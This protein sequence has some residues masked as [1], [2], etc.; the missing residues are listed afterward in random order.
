MNHTPH[1]HNYGQQ[2]Y[3]AYQ[4]PPMRPMLAYARP[5]ANQPV[6][7][8]PGQIDRIASQLGTDDL[9]NLQAA[10]EKLNRTSTDS[11]A[12]QRDS[13]ESTSDSG[14]PVS[15]ENRSGNK[16]MDKLIEEMKKLTKELDVKKKT[17]K[18]VEKKIKELNEELKQYE[19]KIRLRDNLM[20]IKTNLE[21]QDEEIQTKINRVVSEM[22][23]C[24]KRQS[25]PSNAHNA[26]NAQDVI[27]RPQPT[28]SP[29]PESDSVTEPQK[30]S[31]LKPA[32]KRSNPNPSNT[33][34][35]P[36]KVRIQDDNDSSTPKTTLI[37]PPIRKTPIPIQHKSTPMPGQHKSTPMPTQHKSTPTTSFDSPS[38][39]GSPKVDRLCRPHIPRPPVTSGVRTSRP[40]KLMSSRNK[41]IG[42]DSN[43]NSV[44]ATA[45][46][47]NAQ[48]VHEEAPTPSQEVNNAVLD[49]LEKSLDSISDSIAVQI[50]KSIE[51][52]IATSERVSKTTIDNQTAD[53]SGDKQVEIPIEK[54]TDKAI[55]NDIEIVDIDSGDEDPTYDIVKVKT[56]KPDNKELVS[57]VEASEVSK[58]SETPSDA[59]STT[60]TSK[61]SPQKASD[62]TVSKKVYQFSAFDN[63]EFEPSGIYSLM[64][65]KVTAGP[66][67]NQKNPKN[68]VIT[69]K[70][71]K[72]YLIASF[73][74]C[75]VRRYNI[76]EKKDVEKYE[77]HENVV[78]AMIIIKCDK[79]DDTYILYTGGKDKKIRAFDVMTCQ[80]LNSIEMSDEIN[81]LDCQWSHIFCAVNDG[82]VCKVPLIHES[83]T[84]DYSTKVQKF[85][86]NSGKKVYSI[87]CVN[88]NDED[89]EGVIAVTPNKMRVINTKE[90][91]A[92]QNRVLISISV[93]FQIP[94]FVRAFSNNLFVSYRLQT[95][96]SEEKSI[97]FKNQLQPSRLVIYDLNDLSKSASSD[98]KKSFNTD[99]IITSLNVFNDELIMTCHSGKIQSIDCSKVETKW[100]AYSDSKVM[101]SAKYGER[102]VIGTEDGRIDVIYLDQKFIDCD[103]CG[104]TFARQKDLK[105]HIQ[106]EH[107]PPENESTQ[108]TTI[109]TPEKKSLTS[110][111]SPN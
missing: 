98:K 7:Q 110:T 29:T 57:K 67:L 106:E 38:A 48:K 47:D 54:P 18:D 14:P 43:A 9:A 77:G 12:K 31:N 83:K 55:N 20:N 86:V 5:K 91:V 34:A 85:M 32:I 46:G 105:T 44:A 26:D 102:L 51:A 111:K 27:S 78:M 65:F 15:A 45:S 35:K 13:P 36:K 84:E 95:V 39:M 94:V 104:V 72:N 52:S 89:I 25:V 92:D 11:P 42:S 56:E 107:K 3:D 24:N 10:L 59:S 60:S 68:C 58:E 74:D 49:I 75:T 73:R 30:T 63:S 100:T 108:T 16:T 4:T 71:F 22:D 109:T 64:T 37:R 96:K 66:K 17:W 69:L 79:S 93:C 88:A 2:Y 1:G 76:E 19:E 99:K 97:D 6:Y 21:T 50:D 40:V 61:D 53:Q 103:V 101:C 28:F 80:V 23:K 41:R 82:L 62:Q 8:T 87:I 33:F 90:S 81:C 70:S